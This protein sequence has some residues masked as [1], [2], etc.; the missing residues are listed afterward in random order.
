MTDATMTDDPMGRERTAPARRPRPVVKRVTLDGQLLS[1]WERE[2]LRLDQLAAK[3]SWG[4]IAR[5]YARKA[6]RAR[7]QAERSRAREAERAPR[8]PDDAPS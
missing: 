3:A 6:A 7:A 4:W 2:A 1:Y 8:V 5:G